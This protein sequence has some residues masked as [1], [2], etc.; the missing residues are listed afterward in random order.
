VRRAPIGS[1]E[2]AGF[3]EEIIGWASPKSSPA[4]AARVSGGMRGCI[5]TA[6]NLTAQRNGLH[7]LAAG[8]HR[9]YVERGLTGTRRSAA[10]KQPMFWR[11]PTVPRFR[12]SK[13]PIC[14]TAHLTSSGTEESRSISRCRTIVPHN[15]VHPS[16]QMPRSETAATFLRTEP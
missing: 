7:T 15:P 10:F 16:W 9:I 1:Q 12:T 14:R 8:D 11:P 4:T 2:I 3:T 13:L 6:T 5:D